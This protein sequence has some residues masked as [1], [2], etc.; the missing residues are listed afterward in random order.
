MIVWLGG[1]DALP[2]YCYAGIMVEIKPLTTIREVGGRS[3]TK[4]NLL[5]PRDGS[6]TACTGCRVLLLPSL[7]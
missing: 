2:E 7:G 3:L 4:R 5:V 1:Y 6:W